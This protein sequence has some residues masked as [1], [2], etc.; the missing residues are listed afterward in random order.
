MLQLMDLARANAP[1]KRELARIRGGSRDAETSPRR[2]PSDLG[3]PALLTQ[4]VTGSDRPL[5]WGADSRNAS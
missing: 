1:I 5:P 4:S 2:G 3:H